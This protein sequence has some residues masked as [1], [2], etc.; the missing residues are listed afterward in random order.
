MTNDRFYKTGDLARW[1]PAGPPAGGASGGVIEFLGRI[2]QQVKIRGFRIELGEIETQLLKH[3]SVKETIVINIERNGETYLCAYIIENEKFELPVLKEYL[4]KRLPDYMIPSNFISIPAVPLNP[5][6]KL[7]R[8]A[9]LALESQNRSHTEESYIPPANEIETRLMEIWASVLDIDKNTISMT[10]NFFEA[11]GH[12]IKATAMAARLNRE[13]KVHVPLVQAFKTPTIRG[14]A[15]YLIKEKNEMSPKHDSQLLR[16]KKSQKEDTD[17][18]HR[19][20]LVHD[21]TGDVEGYVE[22]CRRLEID[23]DCW[24]I[25][26]E[27]LSGYAPGNWQIETIAANY[28]NKIKNLCPHGPYR[29]AGWSLGGTIAFEIAYQLETIGEPPIFLGLI[30][31][32]GPVPGPG[33]K[34]IENFTANSEKAWLKAYLPDQVLI[35]KLKNITGID[36]LWAEVITYLEENNYPVEKARQL[37]PPHI[38]QIIP[39]FE[40]LSLRELI[41][42]LNLGRSLIRARDHYVPRG[43]LQTGIHYFKA[44]ETAAG[45]NPGNWSEYC[46]KPVQIHEISG[47]HYNILKQPGVNPVVKIFEKLL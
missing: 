47:N 13:L 44:S 16:L 40:Q 15:E 18:S 35:D 25:R 29:I 6:G 30:D 32:L 43:K 31:S 12:S 24:G 4:S 17:S 5:N 10:T 33:S 27:K 37:I 2:D 1:L 28:I 38:M 19:L 41:H 46:L 42:Y 45:K 3:G 36:E 11:G 8:K 20:F 23:I 39:N 21:G 22:F 34:E 14:M 9:L 26:A 7:D